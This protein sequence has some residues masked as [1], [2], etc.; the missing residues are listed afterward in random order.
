[1]NNILNGYKA[2]KQFPFYS[3]VLSR[4][5]PQAPTSA[6]GQRVTLGFVWGI[7]GSTGHSEQRITQGRVYHRYHRQWGIREWVV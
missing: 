5:Q 4:I 7:L 2:E 6:S 1:M 3:I